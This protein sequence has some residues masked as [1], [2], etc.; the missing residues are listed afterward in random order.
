MNNRRG[1]KTT[2]GEYTFASKGEAFYYQNHREFITDC[3]PKVFL[4][5]AKVSYRPD[6]RMLNGDFIEVKGYEDSRGRFPTIKKLWK[7]YGPA[8][9]LIVKRKGNSFVTLKIIEAGKWAEESSIE[10]Y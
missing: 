4:S 10:N 6:F 1:I 5:K 3:Q 2:I 8:R 7:T 9:L